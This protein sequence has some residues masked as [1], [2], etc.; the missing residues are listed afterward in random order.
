MCPLL[1]LR[2]RRRNCGERFLARLTDAPDSRSLRAY[3]KSHLNARSIICGHFMASTEVDVD[4][5][6]R[7][8]AISRTVAVQVARAQRAGA[9][10][11]S[12]DVDA[13]P[14]C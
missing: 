12:A 9:L 3:L 8:C 10:A 11:V 1:P 2:S 6:E 7:Y 4:G 14:L 5:T 13:D